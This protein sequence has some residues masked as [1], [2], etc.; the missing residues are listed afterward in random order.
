LAA[1]LACTTGE[2]TARAETEVATFHKRFNASEFGVIYDLSSDD[3]KQSARKDDMVRFFEAVRL[4]LG[5]AIDRK[6]VRWEVN[7]HTSGTIVSVTYETQFK[8]GNATEQ[9]MF[10]MSSS[11]VVLAGYRI[12]SRDLITQ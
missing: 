12:D 9:F 6:K 8:K 3:F 4:R 5:E 2:E 10:R 1:G 7:Y 11:N